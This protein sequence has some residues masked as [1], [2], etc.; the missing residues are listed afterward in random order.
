[1]QRALLG[2]RKVERLFLSAGSLRRLGLAVPRNELPTRALPEVEGVGIQADLLA[3]ERLTNRA[4]GDRVAKLVE[5]RNAVLPRAT[6]QPAQ[7][8]GRAWCREE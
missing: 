3:C 7:E 5:P 2:R 6:R 8:V 1:M 4:K